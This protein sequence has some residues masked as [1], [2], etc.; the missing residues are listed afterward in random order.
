MHIYFKILS[1]NQRHA[2]FGCEKIKTSRSLR[3]KQDP[4]VSQTIVLVLD[5]KAIIIVC[6]GKG[7]SSEGLLEEDGCIH[8]ICGGC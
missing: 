2:H 6:K 5:V 1:F 4:D 3:I 8:D 7:V